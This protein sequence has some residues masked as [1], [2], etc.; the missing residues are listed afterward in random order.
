MEE[1]THTHTYVH[2]HTQAHFFYLEFSPIPSCH[3]LP[4]IHTHTHTHTCT[5]THTH[6]LL[7]L[8]TMGHVMQNFTE[9][10]WLPQII[11]CECW[12]QLPKLIMLLMTALLV[13]LLKI[14]DSKKTA[15]QQRDCDSPALSPDILNVH[16]A[17]Q[18]NANPTLMLSHIR[19]KHVC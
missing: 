16:T 7:V 6:R 3:P 8:L 15:R 2:T 10:M 13:E 12:Q 1:H 11:P 4:P 5:S 18:Q 19:S 9:I 14:K 17:I